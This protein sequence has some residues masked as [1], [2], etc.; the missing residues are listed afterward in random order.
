M[1][2]FA[3]SLLILLLA[4]CASAPTPSEAPDINLPTAWTAAASNQD[5]PQNWLKDLNA[6]KLEALVEE[7]MQHNADLQ[8]VTAV[9]GQSIAE[10]RIAGA[11]LMPSAN[12]GLDAARQKI[13]TF[14]PSSTGGVIF[15]NYNLGPN[16][17]WEIDLWG[18]LRN[19]TSAALARV[20]VSQAEL[21]AAR[22][23][24]AAQV[25]KSWFNLV[26]AEQQVAEAGRTAEAY[27]E[28]LKTLESRFK[29]GLAEGLDLRRTRTLAASAKADL[30]TRRRALDAARRNLEVLLG[31]YPE[32]DIDPKR[33][34]PTLPETIPAGIPADLI[35]RRPDL[36][37]AE[38]QLAAVDQELRARKKDLLPK[39][40][41]TASTGRSSQAFNNLLDS[42]FSVW[43]LAGNLS[44]P[45]FQG[46]RILANVDR[47]ASIKEQARA[48]YLN[49]ALQA[50]LEV[51]TTL[52][53]EAYLRNEYAHL[54][55]AA[56]EANA[57]EEL[58]WDRYRKGTS[59]FLNVLDSQ[60]TA[61]T[62]RA[63]LIRVENLLLQNRIDLYLALGG[64][65]T[66]E[67]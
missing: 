14:G 17:S 5:I 19:L 43:S 26:E 41:L 4:G 13:S 21:Y 51:E 58:A 45:I 40:S 59:D 29:R 38:R 62:A 64:P 23:S 22:L 54:K 24:L 60:R 3:H 61:A 46:G 50:F 30:A 65:F 16:L 34:L 33:A 18:R 67:S 35:Q 47:S 55:T 12:L 44:Q 56:D 31:R 57:A 53:A 15:E 63:R 11:D 48:A 2:Y 1:K 25:A 6:P 8:R 9:L 39:I 27:Q 28:N 7:A 20:E 49:T 36:V 52:A 10:A 66:T 32:G 42:D 37:A